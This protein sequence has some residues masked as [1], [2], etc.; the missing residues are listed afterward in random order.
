MAPKIKI[1]AKLKGNV[2]DIKSLVLHPMETG[3]RIDP[4]TGNTIDG[5]AFSLRM[6]HLG[7]PYDTHIGLT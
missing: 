7:C 4:D 1:S 6:H 5:P 2:A 3:S